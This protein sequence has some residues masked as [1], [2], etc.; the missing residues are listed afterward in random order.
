[1]TANHAG[2][3]W[4]VR[5]RTRPPLTVSKWRSDVTLPDPERPF[6][7]TVGVTFNA[8]AENGMPDLSK[9]GKF[10][11]GVENGLKA[12]LPRYKAVLVL[13]ITS[14]GKREWVAYAPSHDWMQTWAPGFAKRWFKNRSGQISAAEDAGW[15]TYRAFSGRRDTTAAWIYILSRNE[16]GTWLPFY[17]GQT[18]DVEARIEEHY[19]A[20][21][22]GPG[23]K[24][25]VLETGG[26]PDDGSSTGVEQITTDL[27]GRKNVGRGSLENE[28]DALAKPRN[29]EPG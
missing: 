14:Q 9:E 3:R 19:R 15:T 7:I 25:T 28:I 1:M 16:N 11:R 2:G 21:R 27:F 24:W 4:R 5:Y 12:D 23:T 17:V 20:G 6:K 8:L 13:S 10:L 26:I 29:R 22:L 18:T